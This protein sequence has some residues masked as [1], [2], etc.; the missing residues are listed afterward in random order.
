MLP[1][2]SSFLLTP[3]AYLALHTCGQLDF[4]HWD[5]ALKMELMICKHRDLEPEDEAPCLSH[6]RQW[7]SR[8]F[9]AYLY[10]EVTA[11]A[12]QE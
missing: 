5:R 8:R 12:A 6:V 10:L 7:L 3:V 4:P 11:F 2:S 1:A 9:H